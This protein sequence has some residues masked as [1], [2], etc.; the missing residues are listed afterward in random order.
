MKF[1]TSALAAVMVL[2]I[3]LTPEN[4][5]EETE[6]RTVF[7]KFFAPWCDHCREMAPAWEQLMIAFEKSDSTLIAEVD[8][9]GKGAELCQEMG[10]ENYPT[11]KYGHPSN[12]ENYDGAMEYEDLLMFA[13]EKIG[14]VCGPKS[15][16]LCDAGQ[17]VKIKKL[18]AEGIANLEKDIH[19]TEMRIRE[20]EV[21]FN[22]RLMKL[23]EE[24]ES[25]YSKLLKEKEDSLKAFKTPDI[26]MMKLVLAHLYYPEEEEHEDMN[27]YT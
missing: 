9:D 7:I 15:L 24:T 22:D 1:F 12:L 27:R 5:H 16:E 21:R 8:C 6:G 25:V 26:R 11:L 23:H 14:P 13:S 10:V 17:K 18:Q 20:A 19:E 2:G 4:W 3:E